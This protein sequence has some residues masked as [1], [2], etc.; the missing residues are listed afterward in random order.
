MLG[1]LIGLTLCFSLLSLALQGAPNTTIQQQSQ[2]YQTAQQFSTVLAAISPQNNVTTSSSSSSSTTHTLPLELLEANDFS[3][4]I[5]L[6]DFRFLIN[7]K[8]C[9]D[10]HLKPL[11]LIVVHSAPANLDKRNLIRET[12]GQH[13]VRARLLFFVG[14]V[15]ST[16]QV[17]V[18]VENRTFGDIVQGNFVDAYRNMTY[19][20]IMVLKWFT[21]Y[22]PE[23]KFI[24]KAD[25][26]VFV[27]TPKVYEYLESEGNNVENRRNFMFC[28]P[29]TAPR[30]YRTYRSKWR[31]SP[32]EYRNRF[33]PDYCPGFSI[34]YSHDTAFQLYRAAQ[35][36]PYF[37]I[38]DVHVTGTLATKIG[39]KITA[40]GHLYMKWP[41]MDRYANPGADGL[42]PS[43]ENFL[44]TSP[45]L[46]PGELRLLWNALQSNPENNLGE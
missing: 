38:D 21:Y 24:L 1:A 16:T 19:K 10:L 30:V 44:F 26:D 13:D 4:L 39:V 29:S 34:I 45:N 7:Q 23:A 33:Y 14:A 8:S 12:W 20:H 32:K 22:C 5:N 40:P 6:T 42:D 15:N 25:D 17:S 11:V 27:N 37:W 31:V 35:V 43:M 3:R 18:D 9:S 46:K 28:V 41:K 36:T 2:H